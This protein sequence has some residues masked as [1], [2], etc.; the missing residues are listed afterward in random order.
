MFEE[1][2]GG[3]HLTLVDPSP[4]GPLLGG[5]GVFAMLSGLGLVSGSL[6]FGGLAVVVGIGL[7]SVVGFSLRRGQV[8][9]RLVV[10][11]IGDQ[12]VCEQGTKRLWT[13]PIGEIRGIRVEGS[14]EQGT[15]R[16]DRHEFARWYPIPGVHDTAMLQ[17]L[18]ERVLTEAE[19]IGREDEAP[20]ELLALRQVLDNS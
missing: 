19:S 5:L 2:V 20:D 1:D 10:R 16:L 17:D 7:G 3:W 13:A 12:L 9:A 18:R 15:M 14:P 4:W 6:L 11:R 8:E